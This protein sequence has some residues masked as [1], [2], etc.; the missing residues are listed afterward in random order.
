MSIMMPDSRDRAAVLREWVEA[1]F[2]VRMGRWQDEPVGP[3]R[4]AM[5]Q[6]AFAP[7]LFADVVPFVM[8]NRHGADGAAA[9]GVRASAG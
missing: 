7:E 2:P 8:M 5:Y 9:S 4:A 6:F 3:H 1:R